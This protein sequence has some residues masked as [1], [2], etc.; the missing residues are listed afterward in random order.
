MHLLGAILARMS[1][2]QVHLITLVHKQRTGL[3]CSLI[4]VPTVRCGDCV[5]TAVTKPAP[6]LQPGEPRCQGP[7]APT[8]L[9]LAW[10]EPVKRGSAITS[11]T[12]EICLASDFLP[13][14][15]PPEEPP[16][17]EPQESSGPIEEGICRICW[18]RTYIFPLRD[19]LQFRVCQAS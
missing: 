2:F 4:D 1:A 14:A 18:S 8:S 6:P 7:M 12:L 16:Q 17:P 11:Y 10:D 13:A 5:G 9:N 3:R 15:A 19:L